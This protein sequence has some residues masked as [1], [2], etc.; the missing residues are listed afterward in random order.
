M[1]DYFPNVSKPE[2]EPDFL[3]LG[4]WFFLPNYGRVYC[5]PSLS[6]RGIIFWAPPELEEHITNLSADVKREWDVLFP[7]GN[8][9]I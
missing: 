8:G 9:Q 1:L 4:L 6:L 2:V 5:S 7:F 3:T